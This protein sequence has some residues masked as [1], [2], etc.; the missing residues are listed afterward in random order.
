MNIVSGVVDG[1]LSGNAV[2]PVHNH[3]NEDGSVTSLCAVVSKLMLVDE[4]TYNI[5]ALTIRNGSLNIDMV[6]HYNKQNSTL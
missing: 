2:L 3:Q 1:A 4:V 5:Y 6:G